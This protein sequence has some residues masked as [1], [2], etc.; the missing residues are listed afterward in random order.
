MYDIMIVDLGSHAIAIKKVKELYPFAQVTRYYDSV[1][2]T[3]LRCAER[4]NTSHFWLVMSCADV[5][6]FDFEYQPVPWERH[7]IHCWAGPNSKFGDVMLIPAAELLNQNPKLLEWFK[8]VNYHDHV[9]SRHSWP[10]VKYENA[11]LTQT[12]LSSDLASEYTLFYS[13]TLAH[14]CYEPALWGKDH[15]QLASLSQDNAINLVPRAAK[16]CLKTQVYDYHNLVRVPQHPGQAQD[17]VFISYDE[18]QADTNYAHLVSRFPHAKRVHGVEGMEKALKAAAQVSHTPWFYATFA[19]TRLHEK[20]NFDFVPD[21][22]QAPKHYIFNAL[23][24]SNGL[25]YGH[26]GIILYHKDTVLYAPEWD[27]IN[28]MD[29]TMSFA[30]ESIPITSVY[31]E[32]ATDPYR[33]WR[34]AFRETAKLVQWYLDY[35]CVETF[36]RL[37]IWQTHAHGPYAEWVLRGA[38][39]GVKYY[40]QHI[41]DHGALKKMFR[42]D[43]LSHYFQELYAHDQLLQQHD[44]LL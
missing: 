6:T 41:S 8:D 32:F 31:G 39:D 35:K 33:A 20:W 5:S 13:N 19:K 24:T 16:L 34:T 42:W 2:A 9:I 14:M 1:L 43:W 22:W 18:P 28:G 7:Q 23:N 12:I 11:D 26:M 27:D 40:H 38:Q 15:H 3:A 25:C 21:R 10:C 4:S 29:Y 36:Y 37:K 30:T 17:I 44:K